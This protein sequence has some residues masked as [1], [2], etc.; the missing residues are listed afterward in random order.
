[1]PSSGQT[2]LLSQIM[3]TNQAWLVWYALAVFLVSLLSHS[4][5]GSGNGT[6]LGNDGHG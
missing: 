5:G 6:E 3:E 2:W 4:P 1:M